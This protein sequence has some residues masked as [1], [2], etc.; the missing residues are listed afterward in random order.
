MD[1]H[2]I[3]IQSLWTAVRWLPGL[4]LRQFFPQHR[5]AELLYV[6]LQPR[7][8]SAAVNL[9]EVTS[10]SL[11]LNVINLSPFEVELD[12]AEFDFWFAGTSIRTQVLN[13]L[14]ISPGHITTLEL[15]GAIPGGHADAIARTLRVS[16][17][18]VEGTL[19]GWIDFN[20]NLHR[21]KKQIRGLQNIR[22]SVINEQYR[23]GA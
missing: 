18:F 10:Y 23:T 7:G 6:D 22:P 12:R 3:P 16:S 8:E 4:V 11:W 15:S 14:R 20:C 19:T 21:F 13:S 17:P 2:G 1:I 5:L 9:G